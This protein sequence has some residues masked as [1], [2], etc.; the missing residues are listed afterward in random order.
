MF[1]DHPISEAGIRSAAVRDPSR[2]FSIGRT[3]TYG[4]RH[5]EQERPDLKGGTIRGIAASELANEPAL[6]H[7]TELTGRIQRYRPTTS[8]QS[9]RHN[10]QLDSSG[11]FVFHPGGYVGLSGRVYTEMPPS[12]AAVPSSLMRASVLKSFI[13]SP[14]KALVKYLMDRSG[15]SNERVELVLR[16]AVNAGRIVLDKEDVI[17]LVRDDSTTYGAAGPE[18][19]FG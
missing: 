17:R 11:R 4:L 1:P 2:F 15:A 8:A 5:W 16:E 3:S 6:L 18:L 12:P 13:G 19:P 9:V 7:I 14:R 10:L